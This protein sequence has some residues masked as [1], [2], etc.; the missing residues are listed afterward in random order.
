MISFAVKF[1]II[2]SF[3]LILLAIILYYNQ[4]KN[5]KIAKVSFRETMDLCELPIVTFLIGHRKVNFLL[6]T[7]ASSS[8]IN[9]S[10]LR[11]LSYEDSSK[12]DEL[13]GMEGNKIK[14]SYVNMSLTYKD[15]NYDEE[16]QVVDM[17][18][19]FGNLKSDFG[20]N[21]HGILSSS[22]F[23]KYQYVLDFSELIAYSKR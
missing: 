18:A 20:V 9:K 6:D 23:R 16:F 2:F 19:P 8:I 12:V 11:E 7:G 5:S 14:V 15:R 3:V 13:Y 10:T 21:V 4:Y 17:S 1:T 22:F